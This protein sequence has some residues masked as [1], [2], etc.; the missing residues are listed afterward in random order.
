MS[1]TLKGPNGALGPVENPETGEIVHWGPHSTQV[2]HPGGL[3]TRIAHGESVIPAKD[4]A[5][6]VVFRMRKD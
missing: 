6:A 4:G 3:I 5:P 1:E 2:I